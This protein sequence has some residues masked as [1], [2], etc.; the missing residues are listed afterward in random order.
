MSRGCGANPMLS[1]FKGLHDDMIGLSERFAGH[2]A[3]MA[4]VGRVAVFLFGVLLTLASGLSASGGADPAAASLKPDT[5]A[6]F[7]KYST[8]TEARNNDELTRGTN[9]LWIEGWQESDQAAAYAA[10]K[11][12]QGKMQN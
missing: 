11:S 3:P 2:L 8:L 5:L 7:N 6:A 4:A 10:L 1:L 9:L 12:A